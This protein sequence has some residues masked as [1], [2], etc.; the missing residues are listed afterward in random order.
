MKDRH[1]L[2]GS[3]TPPLPSCWVLYLPLRLSPCLRGTICNAQIKRFENGAKR[4]ITICKRMKLTGMKLWSYTDVH[5]TS[6]CNEKISHKCSWSEPNCFFI[7]TF[8]TVR[9]ECL[10]LRNGFKLFRSP[11]SSHMSIVFVLSLVM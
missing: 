1:N 4:F 11:F 8:L 10:S 2:E 5:Y 6:S 9:K 7:Y 3:H